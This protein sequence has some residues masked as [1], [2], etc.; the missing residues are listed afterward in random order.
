MQRFLESYAGEELDCLIV[1]GGITGAALAYDAALRGLRVALVEK[2]DFGCATSS[3]TSKLIH[4]GFRYLANM[5]LGLVRE[6]LRE[7]RTLE[8]IAPNFVYPLPSILCAY[9]RSWTNTMP[10]IRTGMTLYELLSYDKGKT[11]DPAKAIPPHTILSADEAVAREPVIRREGLKGAGMQYDCASLCPERLTLAFVRSAEAHGAR[12]ANYAKVERFLLSPGRVRGAVVRDL[13][14]GRSIEV[15]ARLT[16]NCSG[17]WADLVLGLAQGG[18]GDKKLRR[19]EGIHVITRKLVREHLVGFAGTRGGHFFLVPWRDHTLIGTTDKE[20]V[21]DPDDWR[22]TREA[23]DELLAEV[24]A[25][26]GRQELR[27]EDVVHAYGGLRPLVDDQSKSVYASSRKYEI[28]DNGEDGLN[29]L[30]TVE[31]GKYT[32]SRNLAEA[33]MKKVEVKLGR[34]PAP[35]ETASRRLEGCDID[36]VE[37]FVE[38]AISE[39]PDFAAKTIDWLA[40]HYGTEYRA[41]LQL[42]RDDRALAGTLDQ[43]GEIGAQ[44]AYAVRAEMA[45]TLDD[46]VFRRTGLGTLGHPGDAALEAAAAIAARELGWDAARTAGELACVQAGLRLPE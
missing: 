34:A 10:A 19:S 35:C 27:Y 2:R 28:H 6:S 18:A 46:V 21:G 26:L 31:G 13:L 4:G 12:V 16:V 22:V 8:N 25:V 14:G 30:L 3:V 32:T 44:V 39:H 36:D 9:D 20:Y 42:A 11:W 29:G 45:R 5:E 17:P 1:G 40:R 33:A 43:D 15:R 24:N 37:A 23:V 41:V 38:A 7:R